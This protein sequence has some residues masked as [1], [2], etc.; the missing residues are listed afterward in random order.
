MRLQLVAI[1]FLTTLSLGATEL[2]QNSAPSDDNRSNDDVTQEIPSQ[3]KEAKKTEDKNNIERFDFSIQSDGSN[4]AAPRFFLPIKWSDHYF[5]G[6]G[7]QTQREFEEYDEPYPN[8]DL[9]QTYTYSY[10]TKNV[11]MNLVTY[12][13]QLQLIKNLSYSL[14]ASFSYYDINT[15]TTGFYR[16]QDVNI[17]LVIA[18]DNDF[19]INIYQLGVYAEVAYIK[20]LKFFDF[21]AGS[22]LYPYSYAINHQEAVF[23]PATKQAST[24][25]SRRNQ[26][27]MYNAYAALQITFS[28]H[29]QLLTRY[30]YEYTS[31]Q[32]GA[33]VLN[34]DGTNFTTQES[35]FKVAATTSD[36]TV[37]LLLQHAAFGQ[38][39][40]SIG[41]LFQTNNT[42]ND[43]PDGSSEEVNSNNTYLLFGFTKPF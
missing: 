39:K 22:Y 25:D 23:Y 28:K 37:Q 33:L 6:I 14:G 32:T 7:Y 41:V 36:A 8:S 31:V 34:F 17:P 19:N 9:H 5:S 35:S 42:R 26:D 24:L 3:V 16:A 1:A 27:F 29:I 38:L 4:S 11:W 40:P 15:Q 2:P 12:S 30:K 20:F 43:S 21:R 13:D 18:I 10:E